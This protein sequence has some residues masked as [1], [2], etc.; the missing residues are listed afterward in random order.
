MKFTHIKCGKPRR[1][2]LRIETLQRKQK[3]Y[4]GV[5]KNKNNSTGLI[6]TT[7]G[8]FSDSTWLFPSSGAVNLFPYENLQKTEHF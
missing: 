2:H 3:L 7:Q 4:I 6:R 8:E 1:Y 5:Q